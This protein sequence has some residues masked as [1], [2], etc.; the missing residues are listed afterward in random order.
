ME[1]AAAAWNTDARSLV[2]GELADSEG[3]G[4]SVPTGA[5]ADVVGE[6]EAALGSGARVASGAGLLVQA[7]RADRATMDRTEA[8][9][10]TGNP[11]KNWLATVILA[12][13][14]GC[15]AR[16]IL[17]GKMNIPA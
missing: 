15:D 7:A 3:L 11:H 13:M 6:A 9:R 14:E 5:G 16:E 8:E 10:R 1:V 2:T 4:E 12:G 17:E